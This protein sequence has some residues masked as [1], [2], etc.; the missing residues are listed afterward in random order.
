MARLGGRPVAIKPCG[1][2][3]VHASKCRDNGRT[4][5]GSMVAV[6][7]TKELSRVNKH[8]PTDSG[9]VIPSITSIAEPSMTEPVLA[10]H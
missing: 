8:Q 4:Q 5:D 1:G 3:T 6:D 9:R 7:I 2:G 10:E